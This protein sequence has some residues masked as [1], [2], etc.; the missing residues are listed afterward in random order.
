M[1]CALRSILKS[2]FIVP[3]LPLMTGCGIC[4]MGIGDCPSSPDPS[5]TTVIS[6]KAYPGGV[7]G[8]WTNAAISGSTPSTSCQFYQNGCKLAFNGRTDSNGQYSLTTAA[9][10]DNWQIA[11][12]GDSVCSSGAAWQ[13]LLSPGVGPTIACGNGV[14]AASAYVTP[15]ECT[16]TTTIFMDGG[17]TEVDSDC[18]DSV[19]LSATQIA[20]PTSYQLSVYAYSEL[21]QQLNS[22]SNWASD[23]STISVTVPTPQETSVMT[24]VDPNN[25]SVLGA[26]LFTVNQRT[27]RV[28]CSPFCQ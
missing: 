20:L 7:Y 17:G 10:P 11:I 5:S 23:P 18:P 25:D 2:L 21:G 15:S 6:A 14:N 3:L 12:A 8:P 27:R 24:V 26:A 19:T 22:G 28:K 1:H 16:V 4:I 13:G 9:I